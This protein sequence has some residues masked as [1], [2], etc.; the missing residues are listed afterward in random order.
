MQPTT[1]P[2]ECGHKRNT[3]R[4]RQQIRCSSCSSRWMN[5]LRECM[6]LVISFFPMCFAFIS[7]G[8]RHNPGEVV[9][10]AFQNSV[11][12]FFY[13]LFSIYFFPWFCSVCSA[14]ITY[15][16][17]SFLCTTPLPPPVNSKWP[18]PLAW[19]N[20]NVCSSLFLSANSRNVDLSDCDWCATGE[21]N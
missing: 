8:L 15:R 18:W 13:L 6:R 5:Y 17:I 21:M 9:C 16:M 10:P 1:L 4:N 12:F 7:H 3:E 2:N 19:E 11:S 20:S 14:M